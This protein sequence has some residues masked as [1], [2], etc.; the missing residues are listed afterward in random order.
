MTYWVITQV[1]RLLKT[2]DLV[3]LGRFCLHM[4]KMICATI[5]EPNRMS[6][7]SACMRSWPLCFSSIMR[8][9]ILCAS[10]G[11]NLLHSTL[12]QSID[13]D[14]VAAYNMPHVAIVNRGAHYLKNTYYFHWN[15]RPREGWSLSHISNAT[16]QR[17]NTQV[18]HFFFQRS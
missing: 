10:W 1:H 16:I 14:G 2:S 4:N 7:I 5:M 12:S 11:L 15:C 17:S 6:S 18:S 3:N 9:L 13:A 8:C